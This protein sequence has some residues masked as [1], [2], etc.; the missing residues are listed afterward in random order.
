MKWFLNNIH[1]I[2]LLTG[3]LLIGLSAFL[4]NSILGF[5]VSGVLFVVLAFLADNG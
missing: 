2:M 4:F 3:F 1:T 5:L